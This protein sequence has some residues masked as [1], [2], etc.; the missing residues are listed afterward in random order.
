[1]DQHSVYSL[2]TTLKHLAYLGRQ[3][4]C[5]LTPAELPWCGGT[6]TVSNPGAIC[7]NEKMPLLV[8]GGYGISSGV[9]GKVSGGPG[10]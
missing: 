3:V 2:A 10:G 1:M 8:P 4:P 6:L 5:V 9:M 7:A